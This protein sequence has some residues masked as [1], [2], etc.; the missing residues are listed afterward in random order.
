MAPLKRPPEILAE[1]KDEYISVSLDGHRNR[2]SVVGGAIKLGTILATCKEHWR[3]E[4]IPLPFFLA[5]D[6]LRI[7]VVL[8]FRP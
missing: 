2:A 4:D 7:V 5:F 1:K 3:I 6:A 8:F